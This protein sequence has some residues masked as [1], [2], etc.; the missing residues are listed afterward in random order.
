MYSGLDKWYKPA[1]HEHFLN[2]AELENWICNCNSLARGFAH[3]LSQRQ[4]FNDRI[5]HVAIIDEDIL[6]KNI[7][8]Q[9]N[10]VFENLIGRLIKS[11]KLPNF[12][13]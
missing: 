3:M 9:L 2:K 8:I 7:P 4:I 6:I 5:S 11:E 10:E 12:Q 1:Y 13:K